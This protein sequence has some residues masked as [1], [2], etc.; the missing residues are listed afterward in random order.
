MCE[1]I[2]GAGLLGE[3]EG[4]GGE[5]G[6]MFGGCV[7]RGGVVGGMFKGHTFLLLGNWME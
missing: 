1:E 7:W 3:V 5:G 6:D 2:C 4:G